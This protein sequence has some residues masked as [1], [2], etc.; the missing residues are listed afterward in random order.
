[1]KK[2]LSVC[3][4]IAL[5]LSLCACPGGETPGESSNALPLSS[6]QSGTYHCAETGVTYTRRPAIYLPMSLSREPYAVYKTE[7][8]APF[9]FFSLSE[10]SEQRY[11][12][13]A[14]EEDLYPYYMIAAEDYEMPSLAEMDPHQI[15][16]CNAE[17]E[18]FWLTPNIFDQIRTIG[19]VKEI[20][21]GYEAGVKESLPLLE[22]PT[23]CVELIFVSAIFPDFA[24]TCTYLEYEDGSAYISETDTG[25]TM[26]VESGMFDGYRLTEEEK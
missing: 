19:V 18:F 25:V 1:M 9:S 7:S 11:L 3:L 23:V 13:L 16:I 8:G 14:D 20:V 6:P 2:L 10:G 21:S 12:M 26:R 5:C 17:E 4:L 15:L 24:Y 22:T